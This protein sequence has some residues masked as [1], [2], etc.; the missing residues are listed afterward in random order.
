IPLGRNQEY[1]PF[2]ANHDRVIRPLHK[3]TGRS[4]PSKKLPKLFVPLNTAHAPAGPPAVRYQESQGVKR[5]K[6]ENSE[7]KCK[8]YKNIDKKTCK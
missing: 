3:Q 1:V 2:A 6:A 5:K 8:I 4:G 7:K